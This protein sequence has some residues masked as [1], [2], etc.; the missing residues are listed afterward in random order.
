MLHAQGG[1]PAETRQ[2]EHFHA[3]ILPE[4][5]PSQPLPASSGVQPRV[6]PTLRRGR[7][8]VFS[9]PFPY[10]GHTI[11]CIPRP[12]THPRKAPYLEENEDEEQL[13]HHTDAQ[14]EP[15]VGYKTWS[16]G[17]GGARGAAPHGLAQPCAAW[18]PPA[19]LRFGQRT[20]LSVSTGHLPT[21][22][23]KQVCGTLQ[24]P[25]PK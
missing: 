3:W 23:L 7:R 14:P 21:S 11:T 15:P 18:L 16:T 20:A 10:P 19:P 12:P 24:T 17:S 4:G 2:V 13:V 22:V 5:P 6:P 8:A 1:D 9:S 25:L